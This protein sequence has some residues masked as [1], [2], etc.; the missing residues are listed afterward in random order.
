RGDPLDPRVG[1]L[2][3]LVAKPQRR[4]LLG[5]VGL[6]VAELLEDGLGALLDLVRLGQ[7]EPGGALHG[8]G[9]PVVA[10]A[11]GG[12]RHQP[13]APPARDAPALRD[14]RLYGGPG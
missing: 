6:G 5:L 4:Q 2:I 14:R 8:A 3:W 9:L 10:V 7:R 1:L 12:E 11:P 13:I